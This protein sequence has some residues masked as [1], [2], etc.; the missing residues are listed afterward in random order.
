MTS[1][2]PKPSA[3][4]T[5]PP[6]IRSMMDKPMKS[7][8]LLLRSLRGE[9]GGREAPD[10]VNGALLNGELRQHPAHPGR[11]LVSGAAPPDAGVQAV[12]AR[13]RAEDELVVRHQVIRA[14]TDP[15]GGGHVDHLGVPQPGYALGHELLHAPDP[16]RRPG[17][18]GRIVENALETARVLVRERVGEVCP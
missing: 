4:S 5:V 11:E 2:K 14:G 7:D 6:A 8:P 13:H 16:A 3:P 10:V 1:T 17:H 15:P 18:V 9:P 12:R